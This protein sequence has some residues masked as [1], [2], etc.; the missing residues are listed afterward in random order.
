M[1][2][3]RESRS[4][5]HV[6]FSFGT[7]AAYPV[8]GRPGNPAWF[9]SRRGFA[10]I[11]AHIAFGIG[12]YTGICGLLVNSQGGVRTPR[13]GRIELY[14]GGLEI[15]RVLEGRLSLLGETQLADRSG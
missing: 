6:R 12:N 3:D 9:G 7:E 13:R 5:V 8:P 4:S 10:L 1:R 14:Q 2:R 11:A 15:R